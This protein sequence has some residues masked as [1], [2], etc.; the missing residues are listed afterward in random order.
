MPFATDS[1]SFRR[2]RE[3]AEDVCHRA[4]IAGL[5]VLTRRERDILCVWIADGEIC[6]GTFL[7]LFHVHGGVFSE[8][9]GAFHRL[10]MTRRAAC[11]AEAFACF[12]PP[13]HLM[14]DRLPQVES[15]PPEIQD[16][17]SDLFSAWCEEAD[18]GEDVD[19]SL[20]RA[21]EGTGTP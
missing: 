6:G 10:G 1:E 13:A 9:S 14:D 17:L 2:I 19:A 21:L 8:A 4:E 16:R 15:L 18:P 11:I 5:D 20:L 12:P 3:V 7:R